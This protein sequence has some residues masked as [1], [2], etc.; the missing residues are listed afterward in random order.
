M[1]PQ[2]PKTNSFA[3]APKTIGEVRADKSQDPSH[4]TP[5]DVLVHILRELDSG[6]R[7]MPKHLIVVSTVI[8]ADGGSRTGFTMATDGRATTA[9]GMLEIAKLRITGVLD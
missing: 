8:D 5:R 2:D 6:K 3:D 7:E 1:P 4:W 9:L